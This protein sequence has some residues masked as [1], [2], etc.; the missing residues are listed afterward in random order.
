MSVGKVRVCSG[1]V[2]EVYISLN[3]HALLKQV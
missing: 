1:F 2:Y 3:F